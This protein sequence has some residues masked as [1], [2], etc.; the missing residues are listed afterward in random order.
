MNK[1]QHTLFSWVRKATASPVEGRG[2]AGG[3]DEPAP[4]PVPDA[5][6]P[7]RRRHRPLYRRLFHYVRTAWTGVKFA[8]AAQ[9]FNQ[10]EQAVFAQ[11]N[12]CVCPSSKQN[13]KISKTNKPI[14]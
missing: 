8:L 14:H 4:S 11:Y 9:A 13:I 10:P 3:A 12:H 7:R 5:E 1:T 6:A 2:G